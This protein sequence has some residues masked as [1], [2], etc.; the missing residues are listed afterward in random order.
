MS[1]TVFGVKIKLD[2]MLSPSGTD[3]GVGL[4]EIKSALTSDA[5]SG[6]KDVE[7]EDGTIFT[8]GEKVYIYS[9]DGVEYNVIDSIASNTLT[10]VND[11]FNAY[12]TAN[13]AEVREGS[14]FRWLQNAISGVSNWC[15]SML[16]KEGISKWRRAFN[17]D[18]CGGIEQQGGC[19]VRVKNTNKFHV[20]LNN[21]SIYLTGRIASIYEFSGITATR[22]E[23]FT[24]E[25]QQFDSRI[26]S[27]PMKKHAYSRDALLGT[28]ITKSRYSS[29]PSE[30]IGKTIPLTFGEIKP[31]LDIYDNIEINGFAESIAVEKT[32]E[33]LSTEQLFELILGI[34]PGG[35]I[36]SKEFPVI[37]SYD[38]G[39]SPKRWYAELTLNAENHNSAEYYPKNNDDPLYIKIIK[40]ATSSNEGTYRRISRL[41]C[42]LNQDGIWIDTESYLPNDI[43]VSVNTPAW[44]SIVRIRDKRK[45]DSWPCKTPLLVS[46]GA[47]TYGLDLYAYDD[48]STVRVDEL[49]TPSAVL[50]KDDAFR[51]IPSF[52]FVD[53]NSGNNN[54]VETN[55]DFYQKD[56]DKINGFLVKPPSDVSWIDADTL[57][58][59]WIT[60][61]DTIDL[62][63]YVRVED[64]I[65]RTAI[66][67]YARSQPYPFSNCMDADE[68]TRFESVMTAGGEKTHNFIHA[69]KVRIPEINTDFKFDD[70]YLGINMY[71]GINT[72]TSDKSAGQL[73]IRGRRFRGDPF[74]ILDISEGQATGRVQATIQNL[75]DFYFNNADQH[76]YYFYRES[77]SSSL[78]TG[79]V[80]L[81]FDGFNTLESFRSIYEVAILWQHSDK[82]STVCDV[83]LQLYIYDIAFIFK[84]S[85]SLKKLFM[86][87]QGRIFNDTWGGRKTSS[88]L[89]ESTPDVIEHV[90]RLKN[91]SE[92]S[93]VPSNGWGKAYA[94]K[95][96][97]RTSGDGGF[98][99]VYNSVFKV[100]GQVK[101]LRET[102]ANKLID[103]LC[104]EF[105]LLSYVDAD[106]NECLRV[107]NTQVT[108]PSDTITLSNILDRSQ[109]GISEIDPENIF[110]EPIVRYNK[111]QATNSFESTIKITR[112]DAAAYDSSY[113]EG[114]SGSTAA[115]YYWEKCKELAKKSRNIETPP[116]DLTNLHFVAGVDAAN[117]A[118]AYLE[119]WINWMQSPRIRFSVHY[120]L[121]NNWELGKRFNLQLPHQ[122]NNDTYE[123]ILYGIEI[124][125]NPPYDVMIEA[126]M[127]RS[128][129]DEFLIQKTFNESATN[130][131]K[132]LNASDV[133]IQKVI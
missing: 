26:Y 42:Y 95:V 75:P 64:G 57:A 114:I 97:I 96:R 59:W 99:S 39:D 50:R 34:N 105:G 61:D 86:P 5:S 133:N 104:R 128:T 24:C 18:Y 33:Y 90:C 132:T 56:V 25:K 70:I 107:L 125:P 6:Q 115:Q 72:F 121:V 23:M 28:E 122:T 58:D 37:N 4:Y 91:W 2:D 3:S 60:D 123:C 52:V 17:P 38:P 88:D 76:N 77:V 93:P 20:F 68:T 12:T 130:W 15:S 83:D 94:D 78:I 80:K 21:R 106:G 109:I 129:L 120:N 19:L 81:P 55:A 11:L 29:A 54:T 27:I 100:A 67:D 35:E 30:S 41:I 89:I 45:F 63:S 118:I 1:T 13:G 9:S 43:T 117:A 49:E 46:G 36:S 127:L 47:A 102:Q 51:N 66:I 87:L 71:A 40:D 8:A 126:I 108:S 62:S 82:F 7:V 124:N 65:Y 10:M 113:V 131:Q 85:R 69:I 74:S 73:H 119:N 22:K 31:T 44:V 110:S 84:Q 111:N 53:D 79:Y 98:D 92:C 116:D 32:E 48:E 16:I 103:R 112:V 101:D 14:E